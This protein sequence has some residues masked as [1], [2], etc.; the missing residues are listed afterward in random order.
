LTAIGDAQLSRR[1]AS[2]A[3]LAALAL[4]LGGCFGAPEEPGVAPA[5]TPLG[6][7]LRGST[8]EPQEMDPNLYKPIVR[9]PPVTIRQ[10]TE[11]H[12]IFRGGKPGD[13]DAV[14]FQAKV[15]DTARECTLEGDQLR[16]KVGVA[17]LLLA[18][19]KGGG[20][21]MTLPV[22]IAVVKDGETPVYSKLHTVPVTLT[23]PSASESWVLVDKDVVVPNEGVLRVFVGFDDGG[24]SGAPQ[25][26][27]VSVDVQ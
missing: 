3:V 2:A 24:K 1:L 20:G 25:D 7:F 13:P 15:S 4:G 10:G 8:A 26:G 5:S 21:A 16:I 14:G 23:P 11:T 9:C 27:V 22:R 18:G 6:Q 17:G 12:V 19:R